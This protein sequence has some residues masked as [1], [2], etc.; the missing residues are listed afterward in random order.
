MARERLFKDE[1]KAVCKALPDGNSAD[2]KHLERW[3]DDSRAQEIWD[4]FK[5]LSPTTSLKE[6]IFSVLKA[7]HIVNALPAQISASEDW[8]KEWQKYFAQS[9]AEIFAPH[10][11][12]TDAMARLSTLYQEAVSALHLHKRRLPPELPYISRQNKNNWRVRRLCIDV[13]SNF[14]HQQCGRWGD[15]EVAA[16]TEIAF[17]GAEITGGQVRTARRSRKAESQHKVA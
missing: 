7:R 10:R 14:W 16:L 3:E 17:P 8:H 5:A 13:L 15:D 12:L 4:N 9:A 6:F 1:L 2:R 11:S